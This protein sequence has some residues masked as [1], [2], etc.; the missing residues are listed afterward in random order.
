M[1]DSII[2]FLNWTL[3]YIDNMIHF[4]M[5]HVIILIVCTYCIYDEC[6]K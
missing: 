2:N 1:L 3:I 6:R 4:R 5:F